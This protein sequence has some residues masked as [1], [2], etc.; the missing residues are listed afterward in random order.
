[1]VP[2]LA[3]PAPVVAHQVHVQHVACHLGLAPLQLLHGPL[4]HEEGGSTCT[5]SQGVSE[6]AYRESGFTLRDRCLILEGR[7][8]GGGSY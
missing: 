7:R 6:Q 3:V 4:R 2:A 5:G 1:M 8:G